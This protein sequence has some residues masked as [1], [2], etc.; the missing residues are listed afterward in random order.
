MLVAFWGNAA[1]RS[2]ALESTAIACHTALARTQLPAVH[3]S[4]AFSLGMLGATASVLRYP[5]AATVPADA[6]GTAGSGPLRALAELHQLVT[7]AAEAAAAALAAEEA[8]NAKKRLR[9]AKGRRRALVTVRAVSW[10]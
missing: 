3:D 2:A 4:P 5:P 10:P 7:K 1:F 8:A 6:G 9:A